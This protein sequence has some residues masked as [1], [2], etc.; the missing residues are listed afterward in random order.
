MIFVCQL[1]DFRVQNVDFYGC[2]SFNAQNPSTKICGSCHFLL[3]KI[4]THFPASD[5][6]ESIVVQR[7]VSGEFLCC[8][9]ESEKVGGVWKNVTQV[10]S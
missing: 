9:G 6:V 2:V 10:V 7:Q 3:T 8:L 1:G 5:W 4:Q